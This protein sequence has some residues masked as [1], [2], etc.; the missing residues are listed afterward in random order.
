MKKI[1]DNFSSQAD[2][3]KKYRPVY[4][5]ILY[6]EILQWVPKRQRCWDCGTGNGQVAVVLADYF[7]E[8][9]ATDVSAK[10]I[11]AAEPRDNISY[12]VERAEQTAFAEASFDLITVAQAMHWFDQPAFNREVK[13]LLKPGGI[14]AIWG[15]GLMRVNQAVNAVIDEFYTQIIGPYWDP[16]RR[17]IDDHYA[18]IIFDFAEIPVS[19]PLAIVDEWPYE[20]LEGYFNSWSSVQHYINKEGQNPV[21]ELVG[22]IRQHWPQGKSKQVTFPIF[23]RLGRK[24]GQR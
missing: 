2:Y 16:E 3:Y 5:Q 4:P 24:I 9:V 20:R 8:V 1:I 6:D 10:Q 22:K 18:S 15:Y 11:E 14:I 19:K 12:K 13:R 23:L 17:Q 21:P 7:D